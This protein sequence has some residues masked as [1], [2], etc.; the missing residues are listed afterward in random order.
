MHEGFVRALD[1]DEM[2]RHGLVGSVGRARGITVVRGLPAVTSY[3]PSRKS[4]G[5]VVACASLENVCDCWPA[6]EQRC[7]ACREI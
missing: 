4:L 2:R 7:N 3:F 6:S 5:V 1:T